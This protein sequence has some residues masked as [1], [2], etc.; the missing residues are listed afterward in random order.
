MISRFGTRLAP[1]GLL[2][3]LCPALYGVTATVTGTVRAGYDPHLT[4]EMIQVS[5]A[6]GSMTVDRSNFKEFPHLWDDLKKIA[7]EGGKA[8]VKLTDE[9]VKEVTS[10][11]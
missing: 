7:A 10:V 9:Q 4:V 8:K 5:G 3:A 11:R 1:F 2:L 6:G